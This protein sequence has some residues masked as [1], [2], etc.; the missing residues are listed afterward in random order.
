MRRF[1]CFVLLLSGLAEAGTTRL[2]LVVGANAG[3]GELAPLRYAETDAGKVA[4]LLGELGEVAQD[5]LILLQGLG[6]PAVEAALKR[7]AARVEKAHEN[8]DERVVLIF[9]FSGHSD[10]EGLELGEAVL[11]F[12]RLKAL[13]AGTKADLRL[14]IVDACRSG[15]AL[16]TKGGTRA[17]AFALKLTDTLETS[18]EAFISSA[19]EDEA[20]LESS[21]VM[22]SLFTHH[23]VSGLRGAA[24]SSGDKR[25]TLN[26][27][28]RYAYDQTVARSAML[29]EGSQHPSYDYKLTGQGELVLTSLDTPKGLLVF[30]SDI[31]RAVVTDVLRDQV[32]A[33][34][35]HG[36]LSVAVPPGQ[37]GVRLFRAAEARGGR[38][39]V[40][41]GGA[42]DVRWDELTPLPAAML[43]ARKGPGLV[44]PMTPQ[45]ARRWEDE[46]T[47]AL[48][49]GVARPLLDSLGVAFA[50]R[51]S[52]EPKLSHGFSFALHTAYG[53]ARYGWELGFEG[54]AGARAVVRVGPLWLAAGGELGPT[55]TVQGFS[56]GDSR[57]SL[58]LLVSAR[59]LARLLVGEALAVTLE[60]DGG[61][62]VHFTSQGAVASFRPQGLL[63]LAARF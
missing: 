34:V 17:P 52:F 10:G 38:V 9:F 51:L 42:R 62:A 30:P 28:Y 18:G 43:V 8:P 37:Y 59:L 32:L 2:A 1:A 16:R 26:E 36:A 61:L 47:L 33:E 53:S 6:A 48:L 60:G 55:F 14:V 45:P 56:T 31:E 39:S 44:Q 25:V 22:G 29:P 13:L 7:L 63:G 58:G 35:P 57:G 5:D 3:R 11:P 12:P 41:E 4:R 24:D 21:E 20:A 19:A 23:L 54:R 40:A 27:A 15:N 50:A 49:A 46:R